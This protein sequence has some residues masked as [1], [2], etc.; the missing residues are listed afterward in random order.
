MAHHLYYNI[1]SNSKSLILILLSITTLLKQANSLSTFSFEI[2]P[3]DKFCLNEYFSD[4]TLVTYNAYSSA[5]ESINVIIRDHNSSK[6]KEVLN[7]TA[8]KHSLTTSGGGYYEICFLN[9][10]TYNITINYEQRSGISAK[11]Y[12]SLPSAKDVEPMELDLIK[13]EDSS[14]ELYHLIMYAD[15]HEKTY[16]DLHDGMLV[17][18]SWL[19]LI[20]IGI[21]V[22][23]GGLETVVSNKIVKSKKYK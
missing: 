23:V 17:G 14:K 7:T 15:S 20:V 10:V 11:D 13:L 12:S 21:M 19:S 3:K 8:F 18:I 16:G 1:K 6:I 22:V 9:L 4:Q 2:Q 5:S